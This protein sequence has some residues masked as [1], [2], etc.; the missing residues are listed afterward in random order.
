MSE[1]SPRIVSFSMDAEVAVLRLDDGK[2]NALSRTMIAEFNAALDEAESSASAV[3]IEGRPDRFSAG[4]DLSVMNAG[5]RERRELVESGAELL[6]RIYEFPRPVLCACTGHALAAGALILLVCDYRLGVTG[7]FKIGLN[8]VSIGMPLPVFAVEI[9]R[10]RLSRRHLVA[11]VSQGR[12]Y[13]PAEA[14]DAGYLDK[15][16]AADE[17]HGAA[18][19]TAHAMASLGDPAHSITKRSLRRPTLDYVRAT[20]REDMDRIG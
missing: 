5:A 19:E 1:Q 20:L 7:R 14:V 10:D 16:V 18:L 17:L 3:L 15:V 4:F 12:V 13:T 6:L 11:A 9:A 8:E 2:A